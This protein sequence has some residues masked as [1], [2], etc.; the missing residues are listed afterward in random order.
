MFV[1]VYEPYYPQLTTQTKKVILQEKGVDIRLYHTHPKLMVFFQ[2]KT[3]TV[4]KYLTISNTQDT[5][6]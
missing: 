3:F 2:P 1:S 4:T 6:H 5:S